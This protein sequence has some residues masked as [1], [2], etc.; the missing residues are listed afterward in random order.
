MIQIKSFVSTKAELLDEKVNKWLEENEDIIWYDVHPYM[1]Y[2]AIKDK[3]AYMIGVTVL[4][5]RNPP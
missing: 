4:Y 2:T 3:G 1:S 5:D